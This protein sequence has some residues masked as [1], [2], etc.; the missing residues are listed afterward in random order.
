MSD[1]T[2]KVMSAISSIKK[3]IANPEISQA[4]LEYFHT[5]NKILHRKSWQMI[6]AILRLIQPNKRTEAI[7]SYRDKKATI[8]YCYEVRH[9]V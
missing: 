3:E 8:G 5:L 7:Q 1:R 6:V 2:N 4:V 9:W